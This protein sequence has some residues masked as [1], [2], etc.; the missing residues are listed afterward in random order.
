MGGY[1]VKL[2]KQNKQHKTIKRH[3]KNMLLSLGHT[4]PCIF[5]R[6]SFLGFC[7]ELPIDSFMTGRIE[8]MRWLYEIRN[9]V[10][11]K[12]ISQEEKCYNDEKKRLKT[13]YHNGQKTDENKKL[14]YKNLEAFKKKTFITIPSPSFKEVLDKYED[15]R[16]VCSTKAKTCALPD[17]R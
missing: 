7:K 3:F 10:N 4:M 9:K 17:K 15:I 16:A 6:Q 14:Y 1:P 12:L 5:C 13:I 2:D 8:L 11:Q